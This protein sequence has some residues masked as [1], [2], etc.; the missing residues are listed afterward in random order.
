MAFGADETVTIAEALR[1]CTWNGAFLTHDETRRGLEEDPE[2]LF[3]MRARVLATMVEGQAVHGA[4]PG[5]PAPAGPGASWKTR[6]PM[7]YDA[8][9]D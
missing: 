9:P 2:L 8:V 7:W 3:G 5:E 4:L 6:R 1:S